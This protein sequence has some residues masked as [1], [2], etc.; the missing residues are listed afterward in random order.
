MTEKK[1]SVGNGVSANFTPE[2]IKK[3]QALTTT[4]TE[5]NFGPQQ[6]EGVCSQR[7]RHCPCT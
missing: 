2:R 4:G 1:G 5:E 3:P 7:K 6:T